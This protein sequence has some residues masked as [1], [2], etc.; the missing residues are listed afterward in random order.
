MKTVIC[1]KKSKPSQHFKVLKENRIKKTG[2][3]LPQHQRFNS[4]ARNKTFSAQIQESITEN[5]YE[6]VSQV[7][8]DFFFWLALLNKEKIF[9]YINQL[10]I[11]FPNSTF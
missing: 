1:G 10:L 5:M 11:C 9:Q 7:T 3:K 2:A 4:L 8:R 6:P